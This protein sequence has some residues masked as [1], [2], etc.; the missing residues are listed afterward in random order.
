MKAVI[1]GSTGAIGKALAAELSR[2]AAYESVVAIA[3]RPF[4]FE[5]VT[6]RFSLRVVDFDAIGEHAAEF[7]GFDHVYCAMGTTKAAAGSAEKFLAIDQELTFKACGLALDSS[8]KGQHLLY[9]SAGGASASS[10]F[11]YLKS[12]GQTE[13]RLKTLGFAKTTILR[14]GFL[15]HH[16]REQARLMETITAPF[17][18]GFRKLGIRSTSAKVE[19][20]ASALKA[21]ALGRGPSGSE[22]I[23]NSGILDL[24]DAEHGQSASAAA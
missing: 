10:P 6:P 20:V 3:R 12:K 4:S 22:P 19:E 18:A 16:G 14:P 13:D 24:A 7:K 2:D 5:G 15:E 8:I 1:L 17:M 11:L 21:C 9:V 23:G